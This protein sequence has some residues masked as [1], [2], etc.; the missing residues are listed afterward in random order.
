MHLRA[1]QKGKTFYWVIC[2]LFCAA[3]LTA[4]NITLKGT[5]ISATENE[6]VIGAGVVQAGTT[7]G[8]VTNADGEF[9]LQVPA[10]GKITVSYIGYVT[11]TI[12]VNGQTSLTITLN[13][14]QIGLEEVVVVGF[15]T[16]KKVNLTGAVAS[17]S[18]DVLT[19][20]PVANIGQALQGVVP[21]LNVSI[22][23]GGL[24]TTPSFNIRGGTSYEKDVNDNNKWKV[25]NGSPLI[26]VDGVETGET[27]L[28]MMNPNDIENIS[29]IKDAS[30]S[31]I[32][33]ARASYG[34]MLIT[35]KSG[36]FN[37]KI[38][39]NYS[40]DFQW[41]TPAN[42]PD[43]L[44]SY[45]YQYATMER[46]RMRG[47]SV[48]TWNETI[49]DAMKKYRENPTPGNAWIYNEG[50]QSAFTWVADVNPFKLAVREWTPMQKHN[51]SM[52]GGSEKIRYNLSLGFQ[53]NDGF[54]K[55]EHDNIKRY[56]ALMSMNFVATKWLDIGARIN[57]NISNFKEPWLNSQKGTL[58]S[59]LLTQTGRNIN[60]PVMTGPDDP[61]PNI[62]TDNIVGWIMYGAKNK[63]KRSNSVYSITP[64][65]ILLP[66]L[67]LK[68]EFSYRTTSYDQNRIMPTRSYITSNWSSIDQTHT[69]PSQIYKNKNQSEL[70]TINLYAD[71]NKTFAKMHTISGVAGFNQEWYKYNQMN[72]TANGIMSESAPV[73]DLIT[74][75]TLTTLGESIS[76]WAIRGAFVR[77]N[78]NFNDRYLL[79][80][81]GRYDGSS[82][83][84]KD[85]RF[86]FF[87][88][89]SAAWRLSEEAFMESTRTWLDNLKIRGNWGSI[90][91][92]NVTNY[93]YFPTLGSSTAVNWLMG[94][95]RPLGITPAG[96]I[97][98]TL[99]WET[100]TTI[101]LGLDVSALRNKLDFSFDIYQRKTTDILTM[102]MTYP[103]MLGATAPLENS[104]EL[105]TKGWDLSVTWRD[106]LSNGLRYDIGFVLSDYQTE[107]T[108]FNGNDEKLLSDT[109]LYEG[110]KGGEIWGYE[111]VGILQAEDF[112][113]ADGKYTLRG[114]SQSKI[115]STWYPGDIRYKDTNE[116]GEV[117]PGSSTVNDPGDRRIIGNNTPRMRYG[118]T[119]NVAYKGFDLN[120]FFQG[121]GKRDYWIGDNAFWGSG[122]SAG[123]MD[124]YKNSWT[125][126][127][128]KAKYPMY[129]AGSQ[130]TQAQTGYLFD[131]SYFRLKQVVVGYTLPQHITSTIGIDRIRFNV[132][133]Y[134]LFEITDIPKVLDPD[135][136]S[137]VYPVMRSVAIGVQVGF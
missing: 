65:I 49:L 67:N 24:N 27:E 63:E 11:Q 48:S 73:I 54:I 18:S 25:K 137:S 56:N 30:A 59:A 57:F 3:S 96:L 61:V 64:T 9:S 126:E 127:N 70:F 115:A 119:G 102:G 40:A 32:Y 118:I 1:T 16:Q 108:K 23:N 36:K 84:P 95:V 33:G 74:D 20:R 19:N 128:T 35:T 129:G 133:G 132:S 85:D 6:P 37:E 104:G 55:P 78:Y 44:D 98:P 46:T 29:V 92:Q 116:D 82:R 112:D 135:N 123:N 8:T 88:S 114:P 69:N 136:L 120:L 22:A 21:N 45:T 51:I 43:L 79:E 53:D 4:Q 2:M 31:A 12:D 97:S 91:N 15:G 106:R 7:N 50:S 125:T 131:A 72:L 134:N 86:K 93:A 121:I 99:T 111:T 89:F 103:S 62:W 68:G 71:F 80:M 87:P 17:V 41:E 13:E 113:I 100:A 117:S 58:W 26:L 77:L 101:N 5:V 105:T 81:N 60:M 28:N 14:D 109:Y 107:V 52:S 34:V 75:A 47:G 130:N 10:N 38:K 42:T 110:Q 122:D 39:I 90:G 124:T 76:E 66:E 83:F 94:G